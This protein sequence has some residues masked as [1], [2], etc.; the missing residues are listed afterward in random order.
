MGGG[1]VDMNHVQVHPTAFIDLKRPNAM[2]K[3]LC[4]E[5]LRGVGGILLNRNG[6]RFVDELG[7]RKH[8]VETMNSQPGHDKLHF[9]ILLS[10]AMAKIADKHVPHYAQKNLLKP[11]SSLAEVAQWMNVSI[12]VLQH[13]IESYN[14]AAS[15]GADSFGKRFFKNTP[16]PQTQTGDEAQN[17]EFFYAG[18][19]TPALHYSMGGVSIDHDG[20]VLKNN[21]LPFSGLYAAGEVTGGVH[22]M[23]RLGGNALTECIVFGQVVG[24][25]IVL[26]DTASGKT[27]LPR[28]RIQNDSPE[29]SAEVRKIS[30]EELA[31]HNTDSDCWVAVGDKVYDLTDFLN[32]HPAG[33]DSILELAGK[34][35][36]EAF[37]AIH[38]RGLLDDFDPEGEYVKL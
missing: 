15:K 4:A 26:K 28:V 16:F 32:E 21:G 29:I 38:T 7:T 24:N 20:R 30:A 5:L 1:V 22:G 23:N 12:S 36:T 25:G 31:K 10:P 8:I 18:V 27:S 33:P 13:S 11:F 37:D 35:G 3:T 14:E 34:D 17:K 2:R 6:K 19:V 9:T